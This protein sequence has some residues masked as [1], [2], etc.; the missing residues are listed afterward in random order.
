MYTI[1]TVPF[2]YLST[3]IVSFYFFNSTQ[4]EGLARRPFRGKSTVPLLCTSVDKKLVND[5]FLL[6][7]LSTFAQFNEFV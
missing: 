6:S 7:A 1:G 2:V 3:F 5:F 4:K